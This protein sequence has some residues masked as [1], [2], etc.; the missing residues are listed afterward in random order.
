MFASF[1]KQRFAL[2]HSQ[3]A[4]QQCLGLQLRFLFSTPSGSIR[5]MSFSAL[6][7]IAASAATFSSVRLNISPVGEY[8]SGES[9]ANSPCSSRDADRCGIYLAH[10]AGMHQINAFYY[11]YGT[12]CDEVSA[13]NAN[14]GIG[15]G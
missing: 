13:G 3:F 5:K 11:A 4:Q 15:H 2:G 1:L 14:S 12:S 10:L 9:S 6:R 8:P 7:A